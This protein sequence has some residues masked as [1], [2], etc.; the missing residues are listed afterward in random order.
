[1]RPL[2]II[3]GVVLGSAAS[4]TLGLAVAILMFVL[5]G[6]DEPRVRDELESVLNSVGLFAVLTVLSAASF[7]GLIKEQSWR[8]YAQAGMWIGFVLIAAYHWPA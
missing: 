5:I 4:I 7:I 1:M 3:T 8:W 2:T 6:L